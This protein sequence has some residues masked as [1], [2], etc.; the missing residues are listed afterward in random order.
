MTV[1]LN[2]R[3]L[4]GYGQYPPN[5]VWPNGANLAISFV[6]NYEEVM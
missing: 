3:D 2:E 4:L 5:P 6:V 1:Q